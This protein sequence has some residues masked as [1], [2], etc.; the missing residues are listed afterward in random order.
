MREETKKQIMDEVRKCL[1][2]RK[3][4]TAGDCREYIVTP[5]AIEKN[6]GVIRNAVAIQT[7][8]MPAG[9]VICI[10]DLADRIEAGKI[11]A[12]YAGRKIAGTY[13]DRCDEIRHFSEVRSALSKE[14]ILDRVTYKLVNREKNAGRLKSIPYREMLDLAATYEIEILKNG[15]L[16][17][18]M[19]NYA[20]CDAYGISPE[21]L[22]AAAKRNTEAAGFTMRPLAS[23]FAEKTGISEEFLG[24][25]HPV[26]VLSNHEGIDGAAVMLYGSYFDELAGMLGSDLYVLPSSIHEVI[27]VPADCDKAELLKNT[28]AKV[29]ATVVSDEEVLGE[30]V[31]RYNRESRV[32]EIA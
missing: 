13:M 3:E 29:N 19:A 15:R 16:S 32:L 5:K 24:N 21:E 12:Q 30:N 11:T 28:V 17:S 1:E 18:I 8:G 22:D 25:G 2:S 26:Y 27:A 9:V 4:N 14:Y 20:L 10:D 7:P 31:Y 23:V 6:N